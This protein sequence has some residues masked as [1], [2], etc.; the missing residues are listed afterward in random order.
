M[1]VMQQAHVGLSLLR[2]IPK[3]QKNVPT[4]VFDYMASGL[5][6]VSTDLKP[7]RQLTGGVGGELVLKSA[8]QSGDFGAITTLATQYVAAVQQAKGR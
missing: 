2:D 7:V 1:R 8:I 5:P 4:K 6:Y 3:F